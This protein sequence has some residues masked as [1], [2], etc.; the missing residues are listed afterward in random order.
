MFYGVVGRYGKG[1]PQ[2]AH[3][4][5]SLPAEG[6]A[7]EERGVKRVVEAEEGERDRDG[8]AGLEHGERGGREG[9]SEEPKREA[10]GK[11]E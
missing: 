11:Q 6:P 7:G 4:K 3:A 10:S 9:G 1:V 2:W 8:E 5:A